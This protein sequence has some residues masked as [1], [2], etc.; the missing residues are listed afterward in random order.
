MRIKEKKLFTN[1]R[2][3][4]IQKLNKKLIQELKKRKGTLPFFWQ[5]PQPRLSKT[6]IKSLQYLALIFSSASDKSVGT[7]EAKRY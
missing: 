6:V 2:I 1:W 7:R 5:S 3:K 4:L